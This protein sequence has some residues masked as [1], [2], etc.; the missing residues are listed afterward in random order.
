MNEISVKEFDNFFLPD[1]ARG[2]GGASAKFTK[3]HKLRNCFK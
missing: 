2:G 1:S 3:V